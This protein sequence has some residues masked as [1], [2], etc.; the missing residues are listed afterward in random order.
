MEKIP[1][2]AVLLIESLSKHT[3]PIHELFKELGAKAFWVAHVE[4]IGDAEKYL[5]EHS[6]DIILLDLG[7]TGVDKSDAIRRLQTTVSEVP[8]VLLCDADD[9]SIAAHAIQ[10]GAQ[11]YLIKG[12]IET[13]NLKRAL[14]NASK[15][16]II[17]GIKS[18]EKERAQFTLDSIGDAVICT[19][20]SG[21]ITFLNPVAERMTGWR[22]EDATGQKMADCVRIV[23]A[24]TRKTILD[25]MAK[26]ASQNRA[27][28]LPSNCVLIGRD[29]HEINIEDSVAPIRD[30][31][32]AVTGAVIVFR[33]VSAT[34]ALERKLTDS[35]RH[36]FLTGLPN[37]VLLSDR[38]GQAISLAHR[39]RCHAAVLFLDLDG[40]KNIN[41][42]LGHLIGDKV[43][44]S[45]AKRLLECVRAPDTV[46]RQGGDEFIVLL[47]E[48]MHPQDAIFTVAR[49]LKTVA[50]VHSIDQHEIRITTSIGVS[51]YPDDGLDAE[52]LIK[53]ADIAM[54]YAKKNGNQTYRF[55]RPE[56]TWDAVEAR[57]NGQEIWQ[58]SGAV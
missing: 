32:G 35:A 19:D 55:F 3:S 5:V 17:E 54:Y 43:L 28:S 23:D 26:A 51:I 30:G 34:R 2:K 53:N 27:G 36:D 22:R 56:M 49:L 15:R 52:T 46:V 47:Q 10:E 9:E 21:T 57:S 33:D 40:F 31:E 41:D 45:V 6:V 1:V 38:I 29:G 4:S 42:S 20:T 25:P 24:T 37:R 48:L 13:G 58:R 14:L 8:I 44:Q 39:H 12:Q 18:V 16:K 7:M 11:D 50:E